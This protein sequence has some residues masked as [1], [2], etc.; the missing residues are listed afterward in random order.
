M[1]VPKGYN[2]VGSGNFNYVEKLVMADFPQVAWSIDA[3]RAWLAQEAS[4][5]A[6]QGI[7]SGASIAAGAMTGKPM[8]M[9]GGI[10][11]LASTANSVILA[12]N[13]PPQAK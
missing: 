1:L 3:F 6:L 10:M 2:G 4:T 8:A 7:A 12:T 11:G 5:T 9:A 13:R